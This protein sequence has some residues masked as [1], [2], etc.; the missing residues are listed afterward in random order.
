[1]P[2]ELE[3]QLLPNTGL[4]GAR[5]KITIADGHRQWLVKFPS[6]RDSPDVPM[7][8][9]EAAALMLANRCGIDAVTHEVVSVG[10]AD[11]LLVRRFDRSPRE[12]GWTRDAF[13][14]ARTLLSNGESGQRYSFFGS[15]PRLARE[16]GRLSARSAVDR[17]ELFRRMVFNAVIGNGDDHDRNHGMLADE[18]RPDAFRLSPAYDLVPALHPPRIRQQA[19][20][21]G[22]HGAWSTRENM[23]SSAASFDLDGSTANALID[24]VEEAALDQWEQCCRESGLTRSSIASLAKCVQRIPETHREGDGT[25]VMPRRV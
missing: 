19:L 21:V 9:L 16:L 13:L 10:D 4:G 17:R 20:G 1:M 23:L 5:P 24:Q 25:P 12:G 14:S 8:R 6:R 18:E 2:P 22:D 7:A 15:Y 3:R 11:V